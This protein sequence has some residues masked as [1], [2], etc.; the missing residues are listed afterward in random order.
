MHWIVDLCSALIADK[1]QSVK[2]WGCVGCEWMVDG[3]W[4][5]DACGR[6]GSAPLTFAGRA[7]WRGE[8][9]GIKRIEQ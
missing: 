3:L 4:M 5:V 9:R 8:R 2:L 1:G 7:L 6:G